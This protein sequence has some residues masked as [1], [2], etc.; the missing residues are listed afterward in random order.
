[1]KSRGGLPNEN[2]GSREQRE[3]L[4]KISDRRTHIRLSHQFTAKLSKIGLK[5]P[6]AGTTHNVSQGGAFIETES[7][8]HVQEGDRALVTFFL[9]PDF[10]G[11]DKTIGLQGTAVIARV[12][13]KNQG[14]GIRFAKG[15]KHLEPVKVPEVPAKVKHKNLAYYLT[16]FADV[17]MPQFISEYPK[18]FLVERRKQFFDK[19]VIVQF[20]TDVADDD[21][22]LEQ[23]KEG[24]A[25]TEALKARVIEIKKRESLGDIEKVTIGR[26]PNNDIVLYNRMVSNLHAYLYFTSSP[27]ICYIVDLRSTNGTFVNDS[28]IIPHR[29]YELT[30]GD[31]ISFGPETKVMYFSPKEFYKFLSLPIW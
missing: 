19:N 20:T 7:W 21:Y 2:I 4:R 22:V 12:D 25:Q 13:K 15:F 5:V 27:S 24:R 10:S 6:I 26:S 11:Q 31:E 18:G 17:H 29:T 8:R 1:M 28:R 16:T 9:P 14:L 23:L 30:A 3:T